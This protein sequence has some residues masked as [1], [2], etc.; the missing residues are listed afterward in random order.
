MTLASYSPRRATARLRREVARTALRSERRRGFGPEEKRT[1]ALGVIAA[2]TTVAVAIVEVGRVWRRGA[3]PLPSETDDLLQAAGEAVA[4]TVEATVAGYQD[5]ST[6]ENSVF[7]LLASFVVTFASARG[8]AYL[9]R[10]RRRLG[11]FR[12]VTIARRHIHH[13][14]PG[15][16]IAFMAGAA[17]IITR[18]DSLKPRLA[19]AFGCG[20]GLTLDESALLLEL[21]DVYWSPEGLLGVQITLSVVA[22]IAALSLALRFTRRGEQIVLERQPQN[23]RPPA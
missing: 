12:N 4:E 3:T 11:P 22:L 6:G 14:V 1:V 18:D 23:G 8:I 2:S 21:E 19:L 9:L 5:V 16:A 20:M 13:F 10:G 7:A 17:A 15:I